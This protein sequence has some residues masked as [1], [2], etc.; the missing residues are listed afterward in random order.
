MPEGVVAIVEALIL[1]EKWQV[2]KGGNLLFKW[3]PNKEIFDK[4]NIIIGNGQFQN[5]RISGLNLDDVVENNN[6]IDVNV[7]DYHIAEAGKDKIPAHADANNYVLDIYV[8]GDDN[9]N[10]TSNNM[11]DINNVLDLFVEDT[12]ALN[13]GSGPQN[14]DEEQQPM[15]NQGAK[16]Q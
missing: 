7:P 15:Q 14:L 16:N 1:K 2:I 11:E 9:A 12:D 3:C 4:D 6:A 8:S 5:N 10:N 13:D